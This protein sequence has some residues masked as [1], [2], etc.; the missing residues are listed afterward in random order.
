MNTH[1]MIN[2]PSDP[3]IDCPWPA[4]LSV[5]NRTDKTDLTVPLTVD[6]ANASLQP[7]HGYCGP[8]RKPIKTVIA[9]RLGGNSHDANPQTDVSPP[10]GRSPARAR[11]DFE[12]LGGNSHDAGPLSDGSPLLGRSPARARS[13]FELLGGIRTMLVPNLMDPHCLVALLR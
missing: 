13:D 2:K 3:D 9:E 1:H 7:T 4:N 8:T 12:R 6:K 5:A 11:S 10:L